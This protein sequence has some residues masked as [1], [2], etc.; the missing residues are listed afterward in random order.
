MEVLI[1]IISLI[2]I[3]AFLLGFLL[4]KLFRKKVDFE[5][6]L[7]QSYLSGLIILYLLVLLSVP[8]NFLIHGIFY[9]SITTLLFFV[10]YFYSI[11]KI[12]F[13]FPRFAHILVFSIIAIYLSKDVIYTIVYEP[14]LEWDARSIWYFKAKQLFFANGFNERTGIDGLFS[15]QNSHAEYPILVPVLGAFVAKYI[16]YWNEYL[17]KSN[18][19]FLWLGI[20]FAFYSFKNM[21]ILSKIIIF[22]SLIIISPYSLTNGYMD[23]WL[24]IYSALSI[25]FLIE[26][27]NTFK[28]DYLLNGLFCLVFCNYI[29]HDAAL[30]T[31]SL[32]SS[33]IFLNLITKNWELLKCTLNKVTKILPI[34]FFLILPGFIWIFYKNKWGTKTD[35]EFKKLLQISTFDNTFTFEKINQIYKSLIIPI[36]F[37]E[38][39]IVLSTLSIIA[40]AFSKFSNFPK[41][42]VKNGIIMCFFPI[43][44]AILF[45]IGMHILYCISAV[46]L[47]WHLSTSADR[48]RLDL[49]FISL[50][51]L[52]GIGGMLFYKN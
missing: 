25:L 44:S 46:D 7:F 23:V 15:M 24:G 31:I 30:I 28:T 48:L 4:N 14:I 33:F 12:K 41:Q 11:R 38:I 45:A 40:I 21:H 43:I 6:S 47:T 51:S 20:L 5:I 8:L 37:I 39:I 10:F 13:V 16:G 36:G 1:E 2:S 18:L 50:P 52:Y 26:Y 35:F 49:L 9:F 3:S 34:L 19:I 32:L 17:P 22:F 42:F 29:K 27:V